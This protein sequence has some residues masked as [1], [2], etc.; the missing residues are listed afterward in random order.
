MPGAQQVQLKHFA[1]QLAAVPA[2][3]CC[4]Q[5]HV[6][7]SSQLPELRK[8]DTNAGC[9]SSNN[10]A[11]PALTQPKTTPVFPGHQFFL[12]IRHWHMYT[13]HWQMHQ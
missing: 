1:P 8:E 13:V 3:C 4:L 7:G 2:N 10:K 9:M 12:G 5:L 11:K 6:A